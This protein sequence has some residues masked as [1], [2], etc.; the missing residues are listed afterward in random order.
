MPVSI[1]N[2][3]EVIEVDEYQ[4]EFVVVALRAINFGIQNKT[5]VPRVV[6]RGAVIGDGQLVDALHVPRIFQ[7][8]RGEVRQAL[9]A[10]SN[11]A[12]RTPPA[13]RN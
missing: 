9:P 3:L 7:R 5:H 11:R 12:D 10:I 8:N 13:P 2:L 1:V 4:G 6:Q